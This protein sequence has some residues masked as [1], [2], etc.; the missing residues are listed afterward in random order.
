MGERG[1][2]F[3]ILTGVKQSRERRLDVVSVDPST[4]KV[5]LLAGGTSGEREI[6]LA[7]GA[8]ARSALEEA[9]FTVVQIDPADK[10]DLKRLMEEHFDVAFI[11]LHL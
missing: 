11:C 8:G 9:G 10:D 7:S 3:D 1:R 6:S 4:C 2:G 5:A